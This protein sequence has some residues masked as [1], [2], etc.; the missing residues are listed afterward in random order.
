MSEIPLYKRCVSLLSRDVCHT[1]DYERIFG[2][3]T[4]NKRCD[5]PLG[6]PSKQRE[7]HHKR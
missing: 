4:R 5:P 3:P 1:V 6:N 2:Y 7:F